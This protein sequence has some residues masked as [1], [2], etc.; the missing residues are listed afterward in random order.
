M[1]PFTAIS[2]GISVVGGVTKMIDGF[3]K[4]KAAEERMRKLEAAPLPLNAY[5]ALQLPTE[6]TKQRTEAL[7]RQRMD[8][9]ATL[10]QAGTRAMGQSLGKLN[11][12]SIEGM[13]KIGI[14][15]DEAIFKKDQM[16]ADEQANIYDVQEQR[17]SGAMSS[18]SAD[19]ESG[20]E[21]LYGGMSDIANV[22]LAIGQNSDANNASEFGSRT[23]AAARTENRIA[24]R[25]ERG[26]SQFKVGLENV[27][28]SVFKG[29]KGL[30]KKNK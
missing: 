15:T 17:L 2:M 22:G 5:E 12:Q 7:E 8:T 4:K 9:T 21:A 3:S 11:E 18:A 6:G 13:R 20:T 16:I 14:D 10:Q 25:N 30:F 1:D 24:Q 28:G 29:V 27:R 19:I 26:G 23:P